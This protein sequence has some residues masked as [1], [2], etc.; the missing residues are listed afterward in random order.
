M[1]DQNVSLNELADKMRLKFAM[2]EEFL[3]DLMLS[4]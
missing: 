4:Q 1:L 3:Y 2:N